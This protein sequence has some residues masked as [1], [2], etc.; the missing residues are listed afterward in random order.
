MN[1][2]T[3]SLAWTLGALVLLVAGTASADA[4]VAKRLDQRGITYKVDADGDYAITINYASEARTQLVFVSGG[5]Q[6]V[7]GFSVREVFSPAARIGGDGI[8]GARALELLAE[9]R[10]NKLG[11]WE[12]AGDVLYFVIKLPDDVSAAQL[13]AAISIAAETA[14]DMEIQLTDGRDDL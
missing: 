12:I 2:T 7:A 1:S 6:A 3:T 14:D 5:T 9:S 8:N 4:S 11:A 13:E 10:R